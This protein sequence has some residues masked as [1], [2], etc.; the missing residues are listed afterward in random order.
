MTAISYDPTSG[1]VQAGER[2]VTPI[3][4][5]DAAGA[6]GH[7]ETGLLPPGFLSFRQS[8]GITQIAVQSPPRV[9]TFGWTKYEGGEP[10]WYELAMPWKVMFGVY[11]PD[12][13]LVG[14]RIFYSPTPI[15]TADD[16]LYHSN[17][18]NTNCRGYGYTDAADPDGGGQNGL[19][20]VCL[21]AANDPDRPVSAAAKARHLVDRLSGGGVYNDANM[22][23]TDGT[24]L[25]KERF[26]DR[27]SL[28]NPVEWQKRTAE[29]GGAWICDPANL[30][31]AKVRGVDRQNRHEKDG[32]PLTV[33]MVLVG[34]TR[35]YYQEGNQ[36]KVKPFNQVE[37]PEGKDPG[38][39][40][41][42]QVKKFFSGLASPAKFNF[43][44]HDLDLEKIKADVKVPDSETN[45]ELKP[46]EE[47]APAAKPETA[48]TKKLAAAKKK[49]PVKKAAAKK[50]PAK[51]KAAAKKTA[52]VKKAASATA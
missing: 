4:F 34:E 44:A 10:V 41:V 7:V 8:G 16:V 38:Y 15:Y 47:P 19:G 33:G 28:W 40:M 5:F 46:V 22:S 49:A 36:T 27:P 25:Y 12:N 17:I 26:P 14:G 1:K 42:G 35:W 39:S 13:A 24:R 18:P 43:G 52:P 6:I 37:Y 50:A 45:V 32:V 51:K 20:W 48:T 2:E 30:I 29:E 9:H 31:M 21:Y 3:E 23:G 11:G